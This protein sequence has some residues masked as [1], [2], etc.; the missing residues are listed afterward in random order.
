M[1]KKTESPPIAE[2]PS[3]PSIE[4]IIASDDL[5]PITQKLNAI[6][7]E[8]EKV[9]K[10]KG[11]L[12]KTRDA[13]KGMRAIEKTIDLLKE[14]LRIKRENMKALEDQRKK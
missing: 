13:K 14:L 6:H 5:G 7:E 4:E 8:L 10:E 1:D 11:G 2:A 3:F 12:G 9:S